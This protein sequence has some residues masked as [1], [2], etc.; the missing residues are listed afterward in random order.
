MEKKLFYSRITHK[1]FLEL[2]GWSR[3]K[4]YRHRD[5]TSD[6]L[7]LPPNLSERGAPQSY[8]LGHVSYFIEGLRTGLCGKY[9]MPSLADFAEILELESA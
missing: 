6:V 7:R 3:A 2:A 4:F 8:Y 5:K 1:Q 9:T